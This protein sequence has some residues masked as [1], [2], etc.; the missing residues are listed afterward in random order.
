MIY[1]VMFLDAEDDYVDE[2]QCR[3]SDLSQVISEAL[4]DEDQDIVSVK[5]TLA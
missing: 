3:A 1:N 5:V 2:D 4:D